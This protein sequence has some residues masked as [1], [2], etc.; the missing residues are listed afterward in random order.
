MSA[1]YAGPVGGA[2]TAPRHGCPTRRFAGWTAA[3]MFD[4]PGRVTATVSL[5]G[6]SF[7]CPYCDEPSLVEPRGEETSWSALASHLSE[8]RRWLDGVV[9]SGGEPTD[10]PDLPALLARL[11]DDGWQV[12][13]DTNGANP[14]VLDH[15]VAEGLVSSVALDIKAP[16]DRYDALTGVEGSSAAVADSIDVVIRSGVDHEFRTTLFPGAVALCDLSSM[17]QAIAGG[18]L[19]ALQQFR[20]GGTLDRHASGVDP[21][22]V[23]AVRE[24]VRECRTHIPTV[25]RGFGAA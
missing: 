20:P 22:A 21:Y 9:V 1:E 18:R 5:A 25:L 7:R 10:D 6:C 8:R 14:G 24:A 16:L 13:L 17:A 2:R 3:G 12:R 23:D 11:T 4:W 15:L 19:W